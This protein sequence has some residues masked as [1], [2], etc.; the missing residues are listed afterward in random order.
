MTNKK[1]TKRALFSSVV[2]LLLCFTMLLGTTYAWFTDSAATAR[3]KITS[4]HLDVVLEYKTSVDGEWTPVTDS[5]KLFKEGALY[6]PGYTEIVF[7]RVSNAGN[8]ALKYNLNVNVYGE[9]TSTNVNGDEFSLKDSLEI[10]YYSMDESLGQ[11]LLG[12]MFGTSE[13][14]LSYVTTTKLSEDT[15]IICK[16]AP[17]VAS[18]DST[19][20]P[21]L[22]AIVLTMP[23][24]VGNEANYQTGYAAP[25]VDL[26][27]TLVATQFT[28]EYDSFDN[29]YDAGA[30]YPEAPKVTYAGTLTDLQAAI[31]TANE[32]DTVKLTSDITTTNLTV[33][34]AITLDLNGHSI[35]TNAWGGVLLKNGASLKNGTINH[36]NA[37]A[38][39]K[40][41]KA[42][43]IENVKI[44]ISN[45]T[46]TNHIT[47]IAVQEGS[48]NG[49]NLIK[50][51]TITG[52]S[53]GIEV[54]NGSWINTI[55]NATVTAR[56]IGTNKG[57]ALQIN[58][59]YV[60]NVV[61]SAFGGVEYGVNILL[62]GEYTVGASFENCTLTGTLGGLY[63][64]DE[65]NIKNTTNCS[66][67]INYDEA[68]ETN[69]GT[70]TLSFEEECLSVVKING[71]T[72]NATSTVAP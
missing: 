72:P 46:A 25:T 56:D 13:A 28:S 66:L 47:G 45:T 33:D 37:V 55:E 17:L 18:T 6:E 59:G 68:T 20:S 2:A 60:G 22:V 61:N 39:I 19:Y 7:L 8:L 65:T 1:T 44:D 38:A 23:S 57:V 62:K 15:G 49:V 31:S 30:T 16:D 29:Q 36:I 27:V 26:G 12:M 40:A 5:T 52:A 3:N 48:A 64:S 42:G 58:G 41:W 21:L 70:I 63:A 50:N 43:T 67:T 34:K 24:T 11:Y 69:S 4:G 54:K 53:Q 32:G 9:T 71:N 51:V 14:A 10:G 35:Q